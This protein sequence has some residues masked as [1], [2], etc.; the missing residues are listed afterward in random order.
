MHS[1][2]RPLDAPARAL[3]ETALDRDLAP[4]QLHTDAPAGQAAAAVGARAF[5]LGRDVFFA[6]GAYQPRTPAGLALLGHELVH[7]GQQAMVQR[8]SAVGLATLSAAG[9]PPSLEAQAT[10]TESSLLSLFSAHPV[11][12]AR[13]AAESGAGGLAAWTAPLPGHTTAPPA[14]SMGETPRTLYHEPVAAIQR[15]VA[16]PV[17]RAGNLFGAVRPAAAATPPAR[18]LLLGA[19]RGRADGAASSSAG[20]DALAGNAAPAPVAQ[21]EA[22]QAALPGVEDLVAQVLRRVKQ[23]LR[24]DHERAGGFLSDLMR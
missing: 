12:V 14:L 10:R 15:A 20:T 1:V 22:A 13:H 17:Q 8:Y 21:T 24:L 16:P 6:P 9:E 11:P 4:I 7:T 19:A 2:G 5:T 3:M 18:T 23:E